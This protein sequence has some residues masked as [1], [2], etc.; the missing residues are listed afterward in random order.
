MAGKSEYTRFEKLHIDNDLGLFILHRIGT[1]K[2]APKIALDKVFCLK[3]M[4]HVSHIAKN[5]L[6]VSKF[7]M[8][9]DVYFEF[10][11]HHCLMK[12]KATH[13]II[14]QGDCDKGLYH[15]NLDMR[16]AKQADGSCLVRTDSYKDALTC[17]LQ[18]T[19]SVNNPCYVV[20]SVESDAKH[21]SN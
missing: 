9:N 12:D 21:L 19:N 13:Q 4:L 17:E 1:N 8:D 6:S 7:D 5:L 3:S 15:F 14:L 18:S 10:H 2:F 20:N 16:C 11:P